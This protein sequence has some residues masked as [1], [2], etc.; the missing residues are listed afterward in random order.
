MGRPNRNNEDLSPDDQL[1]RH[2]CH[3]N[4]SHV[5]ETAM[6]HCTPDDQQLLC[7]ILLENLYYVK[8]MTKHNFGSYV[9]L[10]LLNASTKSKQVASVCGLLRSLD[11]ETGGLLKRSKHGRKLLEH[12]ENHDDSP[13]Q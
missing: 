13:S 2:A 9:L 10:S 6:T 12:L 8:E 4:T 1:L 5:L 11:Q 3:R 7:D